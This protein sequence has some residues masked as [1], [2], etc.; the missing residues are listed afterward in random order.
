MCGKCMATTPRD[1][2]QGKTT[3]TACDLKETS[4]G[5]LR[6]E[7]FISGRSP[8]GVLEWYDEVKYV[9]NTGSEFL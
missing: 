6:T 7:K 8:Q 4:V 3:S 1:Q 9:N 2:S 5:Y